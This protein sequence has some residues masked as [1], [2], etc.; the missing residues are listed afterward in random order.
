MF[1]VERACSGV[2]RNPAT[3]GRSMGEWFEP[4]AEQSVEAN[5]FVVPITG[6]PAEIAETVA[7]FAEIGVTRV[8]LMLWPNTQE[9]LDAVEKAIGLLDR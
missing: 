5:G 4:T 2:G 3:P 8:E 9:S 1:L 6:S 7:Q